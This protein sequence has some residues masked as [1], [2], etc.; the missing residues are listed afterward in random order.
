LP[1]DVSSG[2]NRRHFPAMGMSASKQGA[3]DPSAPKLVIELVNAGG[4]EVLFSA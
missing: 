3:A 4:L 1:E 2:A